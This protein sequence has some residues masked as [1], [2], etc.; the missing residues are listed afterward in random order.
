MFHQ[1]SKFSCKVSALL[2]SFLEDLHLYM[3]VVEV[4]LI[5][6]CF[7]SSIAALYRIVRENPIKHCRKIINIK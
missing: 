2:M 5:K 1:E 4:V 3:Y 6:L 7:V